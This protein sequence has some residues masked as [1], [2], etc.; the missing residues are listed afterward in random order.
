MGGGG[1]CFVFYMKKLLEL[2][3]NLE[4]TISKDPRLLDSQVTVT[5]L[6][7]FGFTPLL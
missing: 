1:H 4:K 3:H 2:V 5:G 7:D 6:A